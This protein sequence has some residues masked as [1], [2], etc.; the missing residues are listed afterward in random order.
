[1]PDATSFDPLEGTAPSLDLGG[2]TGARGA[3][4]Y[5]RLYFQLAQLFGTFD[6]TI[7]VKRGDT[8]GH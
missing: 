6:V 7:Q 5:M 1:M 2:I 3:E 8:A 4:M